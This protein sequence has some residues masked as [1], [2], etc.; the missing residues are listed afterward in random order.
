MGSGKKK[1]IIVKPVF[2]AKVGVG[3]LC[4]S[5]IVCVCVGIQF[6]YGNGE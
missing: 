5:E 3:V 2:K 4:A 6:S 1:N